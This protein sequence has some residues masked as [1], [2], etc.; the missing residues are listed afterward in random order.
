MN[1]SVT[2]PGAIGTY[3]LRVDGVGNGDPKKTGWSD[4]GSLGQYRLTAKGCATKTLAVQRRR[5]SV[6]RPSSPRIG[7]A[8]AGAK[9]GASTAVVRWLAPTSNGG[10]A[11]TKYRVLARRLNAQGRVVRSY[12]SAYLKPASAQPEHEA[13]EGALQVRRG[14][15]QPGRRLT[16]VAVLQ[17][18]AGPL[19]HGQP[20]ASRARA[21]RTTAGSSVCHIGGRLARRK[22]P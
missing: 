7:K 3:Y 15:L 16:G 11:V 2:V 22:L 9:G 19:T 10:A 12:G 8:T 17:H 20:P 6:S 13:A 18:R 5:R 14:G 4:Y 21:L 1:A